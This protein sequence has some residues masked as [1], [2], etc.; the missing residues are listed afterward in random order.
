MFTNP[1]PIVKA[2]LACAIF[3]AGLTESLYASTPLVGNFSGDAQVQQGLLNYKLPLEFPAGI[4]GM[5]PSL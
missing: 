5:R 4:H 3:A 1:N 2:F